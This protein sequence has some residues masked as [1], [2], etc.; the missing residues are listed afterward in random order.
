ME[1]EVPRATILSFKFAM[2]ITSLFYCYSTLTYY[3]NN[4]R[5]IFFICQSKN[6]E[7]GTFPS[8]KRKDNKAVIEAIILTDKNQYDTIKLL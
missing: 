5:A 1:R 6:P 8:P 3:C 7:G 4:D 2:T